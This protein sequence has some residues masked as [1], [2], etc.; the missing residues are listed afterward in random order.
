MQVGPRADLTIV[1]A[2]GRGR[3]PDDMR[4]LA[5]QLDVHNVRY[6]FLVADNST[7]YPKLF[8][9]PLD[10]NEPSLSAAIAHYDSVIADLEA[11]GTP[12][13]QIVVGGFSQGACLTAEFL[14]RHPRRFAAAVLWT[15]GLIGPEGTQW[16]VQPTLKDLPVFLSTSETDPWVPPPRVRETHAWLQASGASAAMLIFQER[17]HGVLEEE[18]LAVRRMIERARLEVAA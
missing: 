2:H 6:L 3:S 7:W 1:L 17:E 5:R 14:A 11:S 13:S 10:D 4:A 16:P 9:D 12:A 8:Q 15:G 18:V